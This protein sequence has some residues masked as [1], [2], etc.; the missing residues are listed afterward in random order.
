MCV[1][2]CEA[3]VSRNGQAGVQRLESESLPPSSLVN[4]F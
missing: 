2:P 4:H 3:E 1:Q